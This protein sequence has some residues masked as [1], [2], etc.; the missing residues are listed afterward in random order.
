MFF[1]ITKEV[2]LCYNESIKSKL[3]LF[4]CDS[5]DKMRKITKKYKELNIIVDELEKLNEEINELIKK[6]N[7]E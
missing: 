2:E 7:K 3:D 5:Y 1:I 6:E 4:L